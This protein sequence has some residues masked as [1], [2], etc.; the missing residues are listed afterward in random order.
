V[1]YGFVIVIREPLTTVE[2]PSP[3]RVYVSTF[4]F[5]AGSR[6][7]IRDSRFNSKLGWRVLDRQIQL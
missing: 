4:V 3:V 5:F 6:F 2:Q 7:T 1:N